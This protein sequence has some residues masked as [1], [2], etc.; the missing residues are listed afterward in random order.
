[1]HRLR[2]LFFLVALATLAWFPPAW[3]GELLIDTAERDLPVLSL[4]AHWDVLEDPSGHWSVHDVVARRHS[5]APHEQRG[6]ALNFGQSTSAYWLRAT[7]YNQ[8]GQDLRRVLDIGF[9]HLH[10]VDLF[11]PD[12][13]G[14]RQLASGLRQPFDARPVEY[15]N[16]AFPIAFPADSAT[17]FYLRVKSGSMVEIPGHLWEPQAFARKVRSE[18]IFHALYFGGAAALGL[19]NLM[20]FITLRDRTF[21]YYV[22]FAASSALAVLSYSGLGAQFIWP[23]SGYW[24]VIATMV[25]F[26]LNGIALLLFTRHLLSTR[27]AVPR[28]DRLMSL[29]IGLNAVQTFGYLWSHA[30]MQPI[31]VAIDVG[32]MLLAMVVALT[33]AARGQ[34]S[35]MFFLAAFSCLMIAALLTALRSLGMEG[36]P[37]VI[38]T[39]GLQFGSAIEMLL[40]SLA[41]ADRFNRIKR[42]RE[43]GHMELVATLKRSERELEKR[44]TERTEALMRSNAELRDQERALQRAK[45]IAEET[46][47][48]KSAFLASM[49]HEIR[50]PMNAVI[51]M[52][53]LALQ[54]ELSGRQR[55]YVENIHRAGSSLLRLIDDILDFSKIE[56]GK[57]VLE[58]TSFSLAELFSHVQSLTAQAAV[59]KRL[60][61]RQ[62]IDPEVP[63]R[64]TGD[65]LR[66]G[67]V[68]INLVDN[69]IKFTEHGS[70][71]LRCRLS[72]RQVGRVA[73]RFDV[74]DS[75]IGMSEDQRAQ[76]FDP[77]TQ[78]EESITRKYGGTGL[79]LAISQRLVELMGGRIEV[80]SAPRAGSRFSFTVLLETGDTTTDVRPPMLAADEGIGRASRSPRIPRFSGRR[81]LVVED[82]EVNCQIALDMLAATGARTETAAN[83]MRALERLFGAGPAAFDLV[84][85][86][87]QMPELGGLA[88]TRRIRMD[89]RFDQLPIIAMTAHATKEERRACLEAG[90][91]DHLAKPIDPHLFYRKLAAWMGADGMIARMRLAPPSLHIPG[92]NTKD[93]L[94]R[95]SGD[96][97]LYRRVLELLIP[98]LAASIEQIQDARA[99]RNQAGLLASV[100]AIAGM[101][102]NAGALELAE[103]ATELE[104]VLRKRTEWEA[105]LESF[106]AQCRDVLENVRT[107][108]APGA[109]DS[110]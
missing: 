108:L 92:L 1:M 87:L 83:G 101:A 90:M 61:Y 6:N 54:G 34:R 74:E 14:F 75:G 105:Q 98:N 43:I 30:A 88:A 4:F 110:A 59:N 97:G 20:L 16:I 73:L 36:I 94:A 18:Y 86:D 96:I 11:V 63:D 69:A 7:V 66:L 85:M 55:D 49:S 67:Q 32:N 82:N 102:A 12:G 42:E 53:W 109:I 107:A 48:L 35:A 100:H 70:V 64:L 41:L 39:Y 27:S 33:C 78:A 81:I 47:R 72:E 8:S 84:L 22:L 5:F 29:F 60:R 76:L 91:Q 13:S 79:G 57:M 103:A 65:P 51:G 40:F 9:P 17:T 38:T 25:S 58:K 95:L 62:E 31:G 50:T 71:T 10:Y 2:H 56:A 46:S 44:V 28:L 21:L 99:S 24:K 80:E 104:Q 45:E 68:L 37:S 77:F 23:D 15:H 89:A 93:A 52:A 26:A 106:V 3:S 19:F